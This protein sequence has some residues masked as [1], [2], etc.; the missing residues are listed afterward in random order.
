M[1]VCTMPM[2]NTRNQQAAILSTS[3][4][5]RQVGVTP[6]FQLCRSPHYLHSSQDESA[7]LWSWFGGQSPLM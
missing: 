3:C 1:L 4:R 7:D 5:V 6:C 2:Q